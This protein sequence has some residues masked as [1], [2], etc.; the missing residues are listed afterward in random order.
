MDSIKPLPEALR[1]SVRSGV[2]LFDLT[3]V[4]EELVF[5]SLDAGATKVSVAVGLGTCY[6][7]VVDDG[8]GVSRDGLVLLGERYATSKLHDLANVDATI[9]S[10]GFRGEALASIADVSLLEIVTKACG[11]P[12]GYRKVMKGAKC[13]YLG[14]DDD[15]KD[16]GTT[17]VVR[18]LFYN[19]PVRRKHMQSS[20]KKVLHLIKKCVLRIALVHSKVFFKV[21]DIESEDD[22]LYTRPCASP[23][24]LLMSGFGLKDSKFLH[25]LEYSDGILKLSGYVSGPYGCHDIKAFQYVYINSRFV[26]KGPIHKLLNNLGTRTVCL[27]QWK[28]NRGSLKGKRSTAQALPAYMLNLLCPHSLYDLTFEP[29]K[30]FVEFKDWA[31][32]LYFIEEAVQKLWRGSTYGEPLSHGADIFHKDN[33][34]NEADNITSEEEDIRNAYWVENSEF[35]LKK[36]GVQNHQTSL[37]IP[38]SPL[39]MQIKDKNW[40]LS[41]NHDKLHI[42]QYHKYAELEQQTDMEFVDQIDYSFQLCGDSLAECAAAV[43]PKSEN[44]LLTSDDDLFLNNSYFMKNRYAASKKFKKYGDGDLFMSRMQNE[45]RNADPSLIR[46]TEACASPYESGEFIKKNTDNYKMPFMQSCTSLGNLLHDKVLFAN[47]GG[48]KNSI[49]GFRTKRKRVC[50][51]D[52]LNILEVDSID[53]SYDF[54]PRSPWL[55]EA[56]TAMQLPQ[57]KIDDDYSGD[58]DLL[59]RASVKSLPSYIKPFSNVRGLAANVVAQTGSSSSRHQFADSGWHSVSSDIFQPMPLDFG[60]Y[61]NKSALKISGRSGE[62]DNCWNYTDFEQIGCQFDCEAI[63]KSSTMENCSSISRGTGLDFDNTHFRKD[64]CD[65]FSPPHSD[66]SL[67]ET[68]LC[69]NTCPRDYARI[70]KYGTQRMGFKYEDLTTGHFP[71]KRARRSHSAPPFCRNKKKVISLNQYTRMKEPNAH[72]FCDLH[73]SEANEVKDLRQSLGV[74][75]SSSKLNSVEDLEFGTRQDDRNIQDVMLE[76]NGLRDDEKFENSHCTC[77]NDVGLFEDFIPKETE[78]SLHY[79]VKWRTR[80]Q[81]TNNGRPNHIH[82]QNKIL[83]ISSGFFHLSG[84]LLFPKSIN[85]NCLAG[86]RVLHQVDKKFI[87]IVAGGTL[88]VIDQHAADERIRLEELR[89]KVL[90]GEGKAVTFLDT[91]QELVLPEIGYQ[92]LHNYADLIKDWGWFCSIHS[93][94][95][96]SFKKNLNVL[97]QQPTLI[98]LL[99]VPCILGVNLTHMDLQE[100]L[101]QLGDTDGASTIPPSVIRV[102]NFKACRGAIMFGDSLLPSECSLIVEELKQTSLCFQ[103]A[104]GRPTTA[105]LV[106]MEAFQKQ[107]TKL[108][109]LEGDSNKPWHGLCRQEVSLERSAQ[110]LTEARGF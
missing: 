36:C 25:E 57:L 89:R 37:Y 108:G 93:Q 90:S 40:S 23:L 5:N 66:L 104:H 59:S 78:E 31:P 33:K 77:A 1:S 27:D 50:S 74:L 48:F 96:R 71:K 84:D 21:F 22:L 105:P 29:S 109:A 65:K 107:I 16:V 55:D 85:K 4:V 52:A 41:E 95:S 6:V 91:E 99:A 24:S 44:H 39:E 13:L 62:E 61:A 82:D 101:E 98:T 43:V 67:D 56:S 19:Q 32:V 11:R 87:S 68:S 63:L 102:L 103:C 110:R 30:T 75:H 88:A 45:F 49:D 54:F 51:D 81:T 64:L 38:S 79:A 47:V 58:V 12:N 86:A 73:T 42:W 46:E 14:L 106:N 35:T 76:T 94:G 100:F 60:Q 3:R 72:T 20:P 17:V 18:D 8:S 97:H 9:K 7:K 34:W 28:A 83:E 69:L 80:P 15:M 92:L 10:F 26:C 2:V 53:Q 70:E